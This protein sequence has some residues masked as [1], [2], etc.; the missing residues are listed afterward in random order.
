MYGKKKKDNSS[1]KDKKKSSKKSGKLSGTPR[2]PL[3]DPAKK[4][5]GM[6]WGS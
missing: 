6:K 4:S 5:K 1:S 3:A 2:G